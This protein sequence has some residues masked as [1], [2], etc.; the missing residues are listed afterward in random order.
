VQSFFGSG[1]LI[2]GGRFPSVDDAVAVGL[3]GDLA[4]FFEAADHLDD[5]FLG[6]LD[7]LESYG[8]EQL[9]F[10]FEALGG[11]LGNGSVDFVSKG[12]AGVFHRDREIGGIDFAQDSL[13][14]RR[15]EAEKVLEAE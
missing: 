2:E 6:G 12:L 4:F 7:V 13:Q 1:F 10:V 5:R 11:A 9:D 8:A 15:L 14:I 3:E